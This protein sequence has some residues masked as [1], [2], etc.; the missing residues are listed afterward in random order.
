M[1]GLQDL[2]LYRPCSVVDWIWARSSLSNMELTIT[3][4]H[5]GIIKRFANTMVPTKKQKAIRGTFVG[6]VRELFEYSA[7]M[8]LP[9][10]ITNATSGALVGLVR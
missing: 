10:K 2:L 5:L 8:M 7:N 6:L 9:T 1:A 4:L 3:G